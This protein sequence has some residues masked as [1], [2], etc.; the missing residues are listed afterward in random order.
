[1]AQPAIVPWGNLD[2]LKHWDVLGTVAWIES[3]H[4]EKVTLQFPDEL[5]AESTLVAA[6]VQIECASRSISAQV[7][8]VVWPILY[9]KTEAT[10]STRTHLQVSV[11]ADTSYN[12]LS[13]DEVAAQH[14]QADCVVISKSDCCLYLS[15]YLLPTTY[16]LDECRSTMAEPQ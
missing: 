12:S 9:T 4:F 10:F 15:F 8:A 6:A 13:V 14:A 3:Q 2:W 11:L 7:S 16:G 5:L 1:M